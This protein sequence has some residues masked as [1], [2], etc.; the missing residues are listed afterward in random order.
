MSNKSDTKLEEALAIAKN[1]ASRG[2]GQRYLVPYGAFGTRSDLIHI[3]IQNGH[4]VKHSTKNV[5]I[6]PKGWDPKT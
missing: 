3:L 5:L 4:W 1:Q 6:S 2:S